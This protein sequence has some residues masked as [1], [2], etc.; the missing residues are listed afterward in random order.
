[1]DT[2]T[3]AETRRESDLPTLPYE[4]PAIFFSHRTSRWRTI[5]NQR[6][7][8]PTYVSPISISGN[9]DREYAT[10]VRSFVRFELQRKNKYPTLRLSSVS[11][12]S[13]YSHHHRHCRRR[14][15]SYIL[16]T[17]MRDRCVTWEEK[18]YAQG[19]TYGRRRADR[20]TNTVAAI[21]EDWQIWIFS[22]L[23]ACNFA[24]HL[25]FFAIPWL[26]LEGTYMFQ[27]TRT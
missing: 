4:F 16:S 24:C 13:P 7:N 21:N 1:M 2:S 20:F 12:P 25:L 22:F 23:Y 11:L 26:F 8:T 10:N 27:S 17:R 3:G 14:S 19:Q 15:I 18:I 6:S 5:G 9:D